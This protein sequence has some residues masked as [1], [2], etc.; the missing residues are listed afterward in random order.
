MVNTANL[1]LPLVQAAQAQK[2]VTVNEALA[3][4]DAAAQLRLM[5]ITVTVPPAGAPD[6]TAY[7]VPPGASGDWAL[8]PGRLAIASNG[9]WVF[10]TPR[11]GWRAWIVDAAQAAV[12]DGAVWVANAVTASP[13]GAALLGET[14]E[15]DVELLPGVRVTTDPVIPA[16][17]VVLGVSGIVT[18]TITG[19]AAGWKLGVADG[20]NRYGS[21][22][23]RS[24]GSWVEGVS[25]QPLAYYAPTALTLDAE[26][27]TFASGRVRL[28]VH[29]FRVAIPR[30]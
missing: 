10:V 6:G 13:N 22:L 20:P 7:A 17:A 11:T 8:Q 9:G 29:L 18:E 25:G 28:A 1:E 2:H 15:F 27:G 16:R 5:S 3:V 12:F 23:G 19:T 14:V 24:V 4:L 26:G 30:V 21:G